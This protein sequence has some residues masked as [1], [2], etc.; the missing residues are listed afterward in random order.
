M[1]PFRNREYIYTPLLDIW[2]STKIV[3]YF[4]KYQLVRINQR[5]TGGRTCAPKNVLHIQAL[6]NFPQ[7]ST[8]EPSGR[9]RNQSGC[10]H[11]F[12]LIFQPSVLDKTGCSANWTI[13]AA[14]RIKLFDLYNTIL[15]I[16]YRQKYSRYN[17][18]SKLLMHWNIRVC[19]WVYSS[20]L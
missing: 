10:E 3:L 2:T 11:M 6:L 16:T 19:L 14:H 15:R 9:R 1:F 20:R 13:W 8:F 7:L 18:I 17:T 12:E 5:Q 4:I